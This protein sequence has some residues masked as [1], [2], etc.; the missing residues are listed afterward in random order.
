MRIRTFARWVI[1]LLGVAAIAW[2]VFVLPR[3]WSQA[4]ISQAAARI[5]AGDVYAPDAM[6]ALEASIQS[7]RNLAQRPAVLGPASIIHLRAIDDAIAQGDQQPINPRLTVLRTAVTDAL[8]NAPDDSYQWVVLYWV[9]DRLHGYDPKNLRYLQMSYAIGPQE[10]WIALWRN[11]ISLGVYAAL[12]S[13]LKEAAL[14]E[15]VGLV[16][17]QFYAGA[18][19]ILSDSTPMV[20]E[21]ISAR[22]A[23]LSESDRK[24]FAK[25][26][27]DKDLLDVAVPGVN[28][29]PS[30]PWQR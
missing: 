17:S 7:N 15:F 29:E 28:I 2:T 8:T 10:G 20:R 18:V 30:R 4:T 27:A 25:V 5:I 12:T 16:R 13:E 23:Q 1:G 6:S 3:F 24:S 26:L 14:N 9:E 19:E 21:R 22:L 11:R